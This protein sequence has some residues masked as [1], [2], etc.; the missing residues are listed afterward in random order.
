MTTETGTEAEFDN[1]NNDDGP[2]FNVFDFIG[3]Q[4]DKIRSVLGMQNEEHPLSVLPYSVRMNLRTSGQLDTHDIRN[5]IQKR[6][7]ESLGMCFALK[8]IQDDISAQ[9]ALLADLCKAITNNPNVATNKLFAIIN[10]YLNAVDAK[11]LGSTTKGAK[12]AQLSRQGP[13]FFRQKFEGFAQTIKDQNEVPCIA[14]HSG[15]M[16]LPALL[17][18][19]DEHTKICIVF[20]KRLEAASE[21]DLCGFVINRNDGDVQIEEWNLKSDVI[22]QLGPQIVLIDDTKGTG[23]TSDMIKDIF[24]KHRENLPEILRDEH[25]VY[26]NG[27]PSTDPADQ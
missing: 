24:L 13:K 23:K 4:V 1:K 10:P 7:W 14:A 19:L 11:R 2:T 18:T 12:A 15:F 16:A 25:A 17:R 5:L 9:K 6:E 22:A 20:P 26:T 21:G 8:M 3:R 27:T